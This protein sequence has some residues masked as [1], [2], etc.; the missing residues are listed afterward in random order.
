MT[1]L[2]VISAEN[3]LSIELHPDR[4]RLV[5]MSGE[6]VGRVLFEVVAG[7]PPVFSTDFAA[8]RRLPTEG[9]PP[10]AIA[11]VVLGWSEKLGAWQLG[12]VFNNDFAASRGSRWCELARWVD[13]DATQYGFGANRAAQALAR[14]IK[15]PL[16]VIPPTI[17]LP[18][19]QAPPEPPK[20]L[21][22]LPLEFGLWT[23]N[24][25]GPGLVFTRSSR[26]TRQRVFKVLGYV[27]WL[28]IFVVLSILS[29]TVKLALPNAGALLPV[30]QALPYLGLGVAL[31]LLL[32]IVKNVVD[33]IT[34]PNRVLVNANT[35]TVIAARGTTTR[36]T[37]T[38][39]LIESVYVSEI[40]AKRGKRLVSQYGELNLQLDKRNF[41]TIL[42][43]DDEQ[44]LGTFS[45]DKLKTEVTPLT[46]G[47][48]HSPLT[49]A[50]IYVSQALG[51]LP[52]WYDQRVG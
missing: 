14:V 3:A 28:V 48:V 8:I 20:P 36:W 5:H 24:K 12:L 49:A 10:D 13:P 4:W 50:G 15:L 19:T 33:I 35:R 41:R 25:E 42:A 31:V 1:H 46:Q 9:L 45:G 38:A 40:L 32:L 51:D 30:P 29:L 2:S 17:A 7:Q 27:M 11:S 37:M 18:E 26:W 22:E 44:D 34:Q 6:Q 21:P 23:L 47:D 39:N 43:N 16:K 52:T